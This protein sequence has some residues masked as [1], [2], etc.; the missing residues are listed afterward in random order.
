MRKHLLAIIITLFSAFQAHADAHL[1]AIKVI[2]LPEMKIFYIDRDYFHGRIA[3]QYAE[4]NR[5]RWHKN[6]G[7]MMHIV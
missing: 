7:F 6:M 2:C 5:T 3:E 4:K 1:E